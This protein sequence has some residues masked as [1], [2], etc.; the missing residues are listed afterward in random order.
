[1]DD[2]FMRRALELARLGQYTAPPNP[3]VGAV[4]VRD[5]RVLAE[6]FHARAGRPHA[7]A[8]VLTVGQAARG[9]TL[10]VNLEPC[11]HVGRTPPCAERIIASGVRR[12]VASHP[13][14]DPRVRG[15]GFDRLR[16]AGVEVT[17]GV[18][19]EE[20]QDL[21]PSFFKFLR[22]GTP[23][24][25]VKAA[26]SVDG[27]MAPPGTRWITRPRSRRHGR[28]LRRENDAILT[29]IATVTADDPLLTPRPRRGSRPLL[30]VV[31][32]PSLRIS[33]EARLLRG[34]DRDPV[35]VIC[36]PGAPVAARHRLEHLG[37]EVIEAEV[38]SDADP[39]K[40]EVTQPI[41][42]AAVLAEVGRRG[43]HTLLVE[44]GPRLTS[45]FLQ[46]GLA[47][48]LVLYLAPRFLGRAEG[49][50]L[51]DA[52]RAPAGARR[53]LP[54][55]QPKPRSARY[56]CLGPDLLADFRLVERRG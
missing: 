56:A 45:A 33:P 27:V 38:D 39:S 11:C 17:T 44:A 20:A 18:L 1:M 8:Q 16:D 29:G 51:F 40:G 50:G 3:A 34:L 4:L 48:R 55:V 28:V 49:T 19:R 13:D 10:Y 12:V 47:D 37:V 6:G 53:E 15:G 14:P 25:T 26:V 2:R 43:A 9:A 23:W 32:D 35:L 22:S 42:L 5:G 30:R 36:A 31:L 46:Q 41:A 24:V 54:P 21:N 7:E 52:T